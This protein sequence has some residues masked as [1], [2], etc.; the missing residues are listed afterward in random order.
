MCFTHSRFLNLVAHCR[1]KKRHFWVK[2]SLFFKE[3]SL[4]ANS[5]SLRH[6]DISLVSRTYSFSFPFSFFVVVKVSSQLGGS[7]FLSNTQKQKDTGIREFKT[8]WNYKEDLDQPGLH[9]YF[10]TPASPIIK[11][12]VWVNSRVVLALGRKRKANSWA[13]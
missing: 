8:S 10:K 11:G 2:C 4:S 5:L 1:K 6:E 3:K 7:H 9:D 12:L 13:N